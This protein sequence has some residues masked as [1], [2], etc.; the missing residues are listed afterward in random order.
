M[1]DIT[2]RAAPARPLASVFGAEPLFATAGLLIAL[3]LLVTLPAMLMDARLFQ[4]ENVWIKPV[5]FQ[6]ALAVYL[7]TLAAFARWLP[8][9]MTGRL[10]YRL[11]AA[12]V[13]LAVAAELI[14]IAGAAMF[15]LA[16]H[17]NTAQ[18]LLARVYPVMG[19]LA[20]L[21]TSASFVYGVAILQNRRTGLDPAFHLSLGIGLILTFLLT[22]PAAGLLSTLPGHGVGTAPTDARVPVMGWSREAGDLRVAHFIATHALHLLPF[23]GWIL[24]R[25]ALPALARGGVWAGAAF[26]VALVGMTIAQALMGR[27]FIP[28][29]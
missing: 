21:L 26:L 11:F 28:L 4:A 8:A 12:A 10:P 2:L 1:T 5:K 27:P 13:V 20:I 24:S 14:W 15:G 25:T 22:V 18:P 9:G 7:L 16:S 19:A 6:A 3:S 23:L 29:F 17:Y